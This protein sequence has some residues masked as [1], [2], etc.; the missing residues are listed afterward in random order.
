L[1]T[2]PSSACWRRHAIDVFD[3][4]AAEAEIIFV[5]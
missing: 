2:A 5:L 3:P 1:A 4:P